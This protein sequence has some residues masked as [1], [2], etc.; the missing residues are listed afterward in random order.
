MENSK[1][2]EQASQKVMLVKVIVT[3]V[4][5]L[6]LVLLALT[7]QHNGEGEYQIEIPTKEGFSWTCEAYDDSQVKILSEKME[8]G[9]YICDLEG[10]QEGDTALTIVRYADDA[11]TEPVEQRIYHL[12]V[13]KE[14]I[15][16]RSVEREIY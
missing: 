2:P 15:L 6:L 10:V 16:Y 9:K 7:V 5:M 13:V 4:V 3:T 1:T 14:A 11:P 12:K 8:E